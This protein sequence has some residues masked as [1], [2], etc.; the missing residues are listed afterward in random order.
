MGD[1]ASVLEKAEGLLPGRLHAGREA[2][3]PWV[4]VNGDFVR[5]EIGRAHV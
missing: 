4:W 2:H 1:E 3:A 5:K